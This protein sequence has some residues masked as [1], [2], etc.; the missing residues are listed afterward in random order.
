[1]KKTLAI[2]AIALA[3]LTGAAQ[4]MTQT[5]VSPEAQLLVPSADFSGLSNAQVATINSIVHSGDTNSEKSGQI[6]SILN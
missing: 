5:E 4:A 1:M 2:T 3:T 6:R